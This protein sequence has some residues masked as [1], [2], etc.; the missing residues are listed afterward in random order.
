M[1][2]E[3]VGPWSKERIQTILTF[4]NVDLIGHESETKEAQVERLFEAIKV[5][6]CT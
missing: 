3:D 4:L 6:P 2:E 1:V 5:D